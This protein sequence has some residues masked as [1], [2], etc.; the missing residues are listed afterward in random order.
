MRYN[1]TINPKLLAPHDPTGPQQAVH[2][3]TNLAVTVR[4]LS[5]SRSLVPFPLVGLLRPPRR[6]ATEEVKEKTA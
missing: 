3:L 4:G 1:N 2:V 5:P 6:K